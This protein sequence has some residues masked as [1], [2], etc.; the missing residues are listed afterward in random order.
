M[1]EIKTK[2]VIQIQACKFL[3]IQTLE[4]EIISLFVTESG[5]LIEK[6]GLISTLICR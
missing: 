1:I 6:L 4:T 5:I 3:Q 2:P